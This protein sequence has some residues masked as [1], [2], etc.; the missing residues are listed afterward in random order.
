MGGG[1][2]SKS[3]K[4]PDYSGLIAAAQKSADYAY[5][6]AQKQQAWAE[7]AYADNKALGDDVTEF[8]L[9]QMDKQQAWADTDRAR[10]EEIYY[11]AQEEQLKRAQEYASAERQEVEAGKAEADVAAQ[12]EQARQVAAQRL[13]GYGVDPSQLKQGALDQGTRIAEAAASS[14][15]RPSTPAWQRLHPAAS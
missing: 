3:P 10:L 6:N 12:S 8:A 5:D 11:P 9:G 4:A 14:A 1:K 2:K 7:T 13:E 15:T